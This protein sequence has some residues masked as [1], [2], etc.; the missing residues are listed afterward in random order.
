MQSIAS[1]HGARILS[2]FLHLARV[3][4]EAFPRSIDPTLPLPPHVLA[5]STC[6]RRGRR[7]LIP[8][9]PS[10]A[11][12]SRSSRWRWEQRS[13]SLEP[14][15]DAPHKTCSR[16]SCTARANWAKFGSILPVCALHPAP[17]PRT[18]RLTS[19]HSQPTAESQFSHVFNP[20][21]T[22]SFTRPN[23]KLIVRRSSADTSPPI[24]IRA[25]HTFVSVVARAQG[26]LK[27]GTQIVDPFLPSVPIGFVGGINYEMKDVTLPHNGAPPSTSVELDQSESEFAFAANVL[28][29]EH[30]TGLWRAT[31]LV[32][33]SS[34]GV[35]SEAE[36]EEA[37]T[38]SCFGLDEIGRAHV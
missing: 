13:I 20:Q 15:A 7:N 3:H 24:D 5:L 8:D 27:R 36:S 4:R 6:Y 12:D 18:A 16:V 35:V 30:D 19:A 23:N 31:A 29:F 10:L 22:W 37:A 9:V 26:V 11:P 38:G 1:T 32:R 28:S 25:P 17:L 14:A 2:N 21:L 34:V 33:V